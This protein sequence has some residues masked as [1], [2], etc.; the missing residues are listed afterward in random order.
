MN[1]VVFLIKMNK[2]LK[3]LGIQFV[4]TAWCVI[5]PTIYKHEHSMH[6]YSMF[7]EIGMCKLPVVINLNTLIKI[8]LY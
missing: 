1:S 3:T 5:A 7:A 4:C 6:K 2:C 8:I